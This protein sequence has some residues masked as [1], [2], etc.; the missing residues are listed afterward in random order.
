[1]KLQRR[2]FQQDFTST[3][4]SGVRDL[5][6]KLSGIMNPQPS[7]ADPP[8]PKPKPVS[9]VVNISRRQIADEMHARQ[10]KKP[11]KQTSSKKTSQPKVH[12]TTRNSSIM[13][14]FHFLFHIPNFISSPKSRNLF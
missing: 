4:S 11:P 10:N 8:K 12:C 7:N 9:E 3:R 2:S 14:N 13:H 1:M 6:E 5:R